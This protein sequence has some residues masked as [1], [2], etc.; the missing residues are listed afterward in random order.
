MATDRRVWTP[1][2]NARHSRNYRL[3]EKPESGHA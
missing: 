3:R 2:W 1:G